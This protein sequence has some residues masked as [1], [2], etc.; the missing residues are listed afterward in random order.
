MGGAVDNDRPRDFR[1][2]FANGLNGG[3]T[4]AGD[5]EGDGLTARLG[6]GRLDGGPQGALGLLAAHGVP[7]VALSVVGILVGAVASGVDD[8]IV[9]NQRAI[10]P[11]VLNRTESVEGQG[12]VAEAVAVLVDSGIAV[13]VIAPCKRAANDV[14]AVV[15]GLVPKF[16]APLSEAFFSIPLLKKLFQI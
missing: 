7:G 10:I 5:V 9:E 13:P 16:L 6:V 4:L 12:R 11:A 14:R 3:D 15:F 2:W 1:Q 8:G